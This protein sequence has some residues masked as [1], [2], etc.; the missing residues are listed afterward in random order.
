MNTGAPDDIPAAGSNPYEPPAAPVTAFADLSEVFRPRVWH[1]RAGA[2]VF[3]AA[4]VFVLGLSLWALPPPRGPGE[5]GPSAYLI[6]LGLG[7]LPLLAAAALATQAAARRE[8]L[9]YPYREGLVLRPRLAWSLR[10]KVLRVPWA[11][12]VGVEV[13]GVWLD[14]TLWLTF[15][16]RPHAVCY[17][18]L[19]LAYGPSRVAA[20]LT[21]LARDEAARRALS[22]WD[23]G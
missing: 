22:S 3:A 19:D 16:S 11:D 7:L 15:R 9:V 18:E 12:L 17:A 5:L 10:P 23:D 20:V 21:A 14:R 2:T 1:Y 6:A 8:P 13:T 4:G